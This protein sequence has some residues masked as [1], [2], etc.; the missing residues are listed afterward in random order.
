MAYSYRLNGAAN[1]ASN[2]AMGPAA[3]S[4]P[5]P[6][7]KPGGNG[8]V[9]R[10]CA[11]APGPANGAGNGAA[12]GAPDTAETLVA[13]LEEAGET[14]LSLPQ[15]G[16]TTRLRTSPWQ[17]LNEAADSYATDTP[18]RLRPP[19]P[20]AARITRMDEALSWLG[21]IPDDKYVLRRIV[22]SRMLVSP[23]TG[24]H[25]FPWRRLATLL[26]A[27]HKAVQRWHGQGIGMMLGGLHRGAS[28][29][30]TLR[31]GRAP[32]ADVTF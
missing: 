4:A 14:L 27:D 30:L 31:L 16:Y 25:L 2:G 13:R 26:G 32:R 28:E 12:N 8:G 15:S 11:G 18:A 5:F 19:T 20:N 29:N 24:R 10:A 7:V 17:V 9:G 22:A 23:L 3:P 21:L 6:P 1:G